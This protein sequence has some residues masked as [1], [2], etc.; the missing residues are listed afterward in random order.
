M[1][2]RIHVSLLWLTAMSVAACTGSATPVG[3]PPKTTKPATA[4]GVAQADAGGTVKRPQQ[5]SAKT[6]VAE[7]RPINYA[8]PSSGCVDRCGEENHQHREGPMVE[9][10][11]DG[12]GGVAEGPHPPIDRSQSGGAAED[13]GLYQDLSD[14]EI[15]EGDPR[16]GRS[17]GRRGMPDAR[18]VRPSEV[19]GQKLQRFRGSRGPDEG[20]GGGGGH[21]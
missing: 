20:R 9:G 4:E 18:K 19:G 8:L 6:A 21:A 17:F 11:P 3:E 5:S 7:E 2:I 1:R 15:R 13:D 12:A 16:G 14:G 10:L